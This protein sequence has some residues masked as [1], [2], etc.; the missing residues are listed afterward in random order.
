MYND[1]HGVVGNTWYIMLICVVELCEL[2][3]KVNVCVP[4]LTLGDHVRLWLCHYVCS[5][6]VDA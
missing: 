4:L 2:L 3:I 5:L 6:R 1:D